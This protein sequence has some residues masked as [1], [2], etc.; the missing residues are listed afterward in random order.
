[1]IA[2]L[3][4]EA[5]RGERAQAGRERERVLGL[6]QRR[7]AL[8]EHDARRVAAAAVLVAVVHAR[9]VLLERCRHALFLLLF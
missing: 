8:F 1:M 3:E 9:R 5:E 4:Q 7:Q 6:L 2:R